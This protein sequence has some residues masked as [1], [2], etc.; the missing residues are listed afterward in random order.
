MSETEGKLDA[1]GI[2]RAEAGAEFHLPARPVENH[3]PFGA[4]WKKVAL[5]M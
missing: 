1:P 3:G 2:F 4:L 5:P